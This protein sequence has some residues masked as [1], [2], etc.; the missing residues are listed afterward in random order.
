MRVGVVTFPG[1][2]DDGDAAPEATISLREFEA[3]IAATEDDEV[4]REAV[5]LKRG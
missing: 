4:L 3:H 1:S 5:E 2:L